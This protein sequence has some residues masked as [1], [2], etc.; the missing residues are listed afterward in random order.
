MGWMGWMGA[1]GAIGGNRLNLCYICFYIHDKHMLNFDF[2]SC[3]Q[4]LNIGILNVELI[5]S[6]I[7]LYMCIVSF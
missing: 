6:Y 3:A 4:I 1:M 5:E 2:D 7:Y